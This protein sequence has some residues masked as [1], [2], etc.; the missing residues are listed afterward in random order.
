MRIHKGDTVCHFKR[1]TLTE[2][3]I[4]ENINLYMYRVLDFAKKQENSWLFMRL[5][6]TEN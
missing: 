2:K 4:S 6:M 5:C 1:E 3:Q